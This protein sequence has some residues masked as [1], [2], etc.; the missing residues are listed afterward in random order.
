MKLSLN[1]I[2][3]H[4]SADLSRQ[5]S[6]QIVERFNEVSAEIDGV[7]AMQYDTKNLYVV[8]IK[9]ASESFTEAHIPEINK[10]V[11]LPARIDAHTTHKSTSVFIIKDVS[12]VFEWATYKDF[13]Q[14]SE[15]TVPTLHLDEKYHDGSWRNLIASSDI[16]LEVDNKTIT[17]RPDMWGHRGFAR[18]IA[19]FMNLPFKQ[20]EAVID[21]LHDTLHVVFN[22]V[23]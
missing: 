12:G 20:Q 23:E 2:F 9:S 4:I 5:N 14:E 8:V 15:S 17:H 10:S 21:S 6:T 16:I 18:E 7:H 3:D 19:A 22:T 1:W 11:N 13:G